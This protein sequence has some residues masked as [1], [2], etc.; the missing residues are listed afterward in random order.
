MEPYNS[1]EELLLSS[2]TK[3]NDVGINYE[4]EILPLQKRKILK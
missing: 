3:A 4:N 2:I 1:I